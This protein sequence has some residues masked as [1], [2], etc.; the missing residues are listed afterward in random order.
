MI[1]INFFFEHSN[2]VLCI[3]KRVIEE[4]YAIEAPKLLTER[5]VEDERLMISNGKCRPTAPNCDECEDNPDEECRAC[6]CKICAGKEEENT[7]LICDECD[8][9]F[10]MKC[11]NPPLLELPEEAYWYCPECKNDE[12]E[13]V[14]VYIPLLIICHNFYYRC[15]YTI[16]FI[17]GRRHIEKDKKATR[18]PRKRA[19]LGWWNGLCSETKSLLH[20]SF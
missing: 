6:G 17:T 16:L 12:N 11:L 13:I 9:M 10:H 18:P 3:Q 8:D 4:I 5:T 19:K 15:H 7:L 1:C 14:K 20:G 2:T